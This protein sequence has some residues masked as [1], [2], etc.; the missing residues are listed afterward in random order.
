MFLM[1][2]N[3]WKYKPMEHGLRMTKLC[4]E[5]Q[6]NRSFV[7]VIPA[8]YFTLYTIPIFEM[9]TKRSVLECSVCHTHIYIDPRERAGSSSGSREQTKYKEEKTEKQ[10]ENKAQQ[11]NHK[12]LPCPLCETRLRVPVIDKL[13]KVTCPNCKCK[14]P[15][16]HGTPEGDPEWGAQSPFRDAAL[17][18]DS[19]VSFCLYFPIVLLKKMPF[20]P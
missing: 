17:S 8:Q 1:W 6:R 10:T 4:P 2:G 13:I 3:K 14:F 9:K 15:V 11:L 19:P 16:R 18:L 20:L 7:E 5:C 12:E